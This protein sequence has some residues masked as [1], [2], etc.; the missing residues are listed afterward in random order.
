MLKGTTRK[1]VN[2]MYEIYHHGVKGQKWG[3]RRYQNKDGSL[4]AAGKKRYQARK[5][6]KKEYRNKLK[7]IA[8]RSSNNRSDV[9]IARAA[10]EDTSKKVMNSVKKAIASQI[11][12]DV[13]SNSSNYT[14]MSKADLQKRII[15]VAKNAT[16]DYAK[17]EIY[18]KSVAKKY[19][20]EGKKDKRYKKDPLLTR[21]Q[22][23]DIGLSTAKNAYPYASRIAGMKYTQAKNQRAANEARFNSWGGN[24]LEAKYDDI[25]NL[26]S[27][28]YRFK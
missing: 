2:K 13:L 25:V 24:I 27:D 9:A 28:E 12:S 3:V 26:S 21:E 17:N 7:K 5:E 8:S 19:D 10:Q 15:S 11:I 16:M 4:I 18:A 23:F 20:D 22:I 6:K 1:E 14:S